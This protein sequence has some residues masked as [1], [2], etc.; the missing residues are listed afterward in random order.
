MASEPPSPPP[1]KLPF[2]ELVAMIAS[3]TA[4]NALAIDMMLPALERIGSDLKV[5][6]PNDP[7]LVILVYLFSSGVAQLFYGPLA[8]RFGRR[9]VLLGALSLYVVAAALSVIA[10]SFGFLLAS[11]VLQG[12]TT[13]AGRVVGVAVVRDIYAGRR[14]AEVMSLAMT[15]F[16]IAPILAPGLG[17]LFLTVG[18]WRG[19]FA[20]LS[21]FG[22]VMIAWV[23][24]RLP[25]TLAPE[26]RAP[27]A[28]GRVAAA[29]GEVLGHRI[30][31]GYMLASLLMFAA[32]MAYLSSAD[33]I[34]S[35]TFGLGDL[36]PLAFGAVALSLAAASIANA[37]L[38][39][40]FGMRLISHS[41]TCLFV[42]ACLVHLA[43]VLAGLESLPV[44]MALQMIA[45]FG[46]GLMLS[47]FTS[48]ALEPMGH[49]AGVASS[50]L[51]FATM[52]GSALLGG[53]IARHYDG[54]TTPLVIGFAVTSVSTLLV[55]V[56]TE[57]G[58]LFGARPR[59]E[60]AAE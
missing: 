27:L 51:G 38:V 60:A 31:L 20:L 24:I 52:C 43:V 13:A 58:R 50:A 16:M 34:F 42:G 2:I 18:E 25:E 49:V 12:V 33:Q 56:V 5:G 23:A 41:A 11:R 44:F 30:P 40:R 47:N 9:P 1:R 45:F 10:P 59:A 4:L 22:V 57:K 37:R 36:F 6:D 29:F 54:T 19:L 15:V 48:I 7:Q 53:F 35:E 28:P 3:L 32:P 39:G 21:F 8:D 14:M 46:V 55:V 26:K 17:Q